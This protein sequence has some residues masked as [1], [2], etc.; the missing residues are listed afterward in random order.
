MWSHSTT[1]QPATYHPHIHLWNNT[2]QTADL[3]SPCDPST[4]MCHYP[5]ALY[6]S[7]WPPAKGRQISSLVRSH[8]LVARVLSAGVVV[9]AGVGS[10]DGGVRI[11]AGCYLDWSGL[12][13]I[14]N[15]FLFV[16]DDAAPQSGA[17]AERYWCRSKQSQQRKNFFHKNEIGGQSPFRFC[18]KTVP[19]ILSREEFWFL[20]KLDIGHSWESLKM[21]IR[22]TRFNHRSVSTHIFWKLARLPCENDP[23]WKLVPSL[24]SF[25]PSDKFPSR[26]FLWIL[27]ETNLASFL[28]SKFNRNGSP[29]IAPCILKHI[30]WFDINVLKSLQGHCKEFLKQVQLFNIR[31]RADWK[32]QICEGQ[33]VI[34]WFQTVS[35]WV[36]ELLTGA[37]LS[38]RREQ[39]SYSARSRPGQP[40][41]R[42]EI[43][44]SLCLV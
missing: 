18:E 6:L 32:I 36:A 35:I 13:R 24:K 3:Q 23:I 9:A 27:T 44:T 38:L 29:V 11:A 17:N 12:W 15:L 22:N 41:V 34:S 16:P 28:F 1:F 8:H 37:L 14:S 31:C 5:V 7:S 25:T 39:S 2:C 21:W 30:K 10:D 4:P 19:N 42:Y 33:H 43:G 40:E 26:H 20:V